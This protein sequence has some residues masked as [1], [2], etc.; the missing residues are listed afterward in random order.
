MV[1]IIIPGRSLGKTR[2]EQQKNLERT[3]WSAGLSKAQMDKCK[4][5][6]KTKGKRWYSQQEIDNV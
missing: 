4:Y 6:E 2:S 3:G 5:L 1:A